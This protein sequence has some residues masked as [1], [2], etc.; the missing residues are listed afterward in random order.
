MVRTLIVCLFA[1]LVLTSHAVAAPATES[2]PVLQRV[3][4]EVKTV[5]Q[6]TKQNAQAIARSIKEQ[7]AA[8]KAELAA[9]RK[10]AR[11][12][13]KTAEKLQA[14]LVSLQE[15]EVSLERLLESKQDIM[16]KIQNTV[17]DNSSLLLSSGPQYPAK[18]LEENWRDQL[19][20]LTTPER[21][22]KLDEIRFLLQSLQASIAASGRI[23]RVG[24]P[25]HMRDGRQVDAEVL[26]LGALQAFYTA[27]GETGF[28]IRNQSL[29]L[30]EAAVYE[31]DS[32]QSNYIAAALGGDAI[33]PVDITR[34]EILMNPPKRHTFI[35]AIKD[36]GFFAWPILIAGCVGLLLVLERCFVLSRV[37]VNGKEAVAKIVSGAKNVLHSFGATPAE[38]VLRRMCGFEAA[39]EKALPMEGAHT[40]S[41]P[42]C[43]GPEMME[44]RLEEAILDELPPLERFLQTIRVLAAIAPLLGLLGTVSGIIQT[45]RIITAHG[46]G[47]P[48]MLSAGISEALMTTEMGLL[49]AIPLLLC[50]HFLTRRVNS[51]ML[52]LEGAG[53]AL[54]A[55]G[56]RG[57]QG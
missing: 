37:R 28:L 12:S 35:T 14:K 19:K 36:G 42:K 9:V 40:C 48:K 55:T 2:E 34:G 16:R 6:E 20:V 47:D 7:R 33:L 23:A 50:H 27:Q 38:R 39:P 41:G 46:N 54:I 56:K 30:P 13:K 52:D 8:M 53:T 26:H 4:K 5:K 43:Y 29:S 22:P 24:Q 31:P 32:E 15:Q 25:V 3:A 11:A 21:F 18:G 49:V 10:R 45:F 51:I 44:R 57:E 1:S 17:R